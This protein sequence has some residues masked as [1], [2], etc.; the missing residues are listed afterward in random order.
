MDHHSG[1]LRLWAETTLDYEK[2]QAH[3]VIVVAKVIGRNGECPVFRQPLSE[4]AALE[5]EQN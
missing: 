2:A 3:F 5:W 4:A 1:V